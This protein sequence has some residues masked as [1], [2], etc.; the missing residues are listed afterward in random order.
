M[1]G[2]DDKKTV[3]DHVALILDGNRRWAEER[4][5]SGSEGHFAGYQTMRQ[6]P[7][8]F[9][10]R[11]VE[12]VSLFVF[13]TENWNRSP[14]EVN[15]LM[16]L[17]RQAVDEEKKTALEKGVR[18][19]VS[20]RLEELPGDLPDACR[21]LM[22]ATRGGKEGALNLCLNYGGR[23]E[24]E[25]A[26]KAIIKAGIQPDQVTE[27]LIRKYLY[28]GELPDPDIIVRTSGEMRTSG[29]LLWESHYAELFFLNKFW[30]DFEERDAKRI[31]EEYEKRNR[32][33]GGN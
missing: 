14:E 9:F 21:E 12:V 32:R 13:S 25:D 15:Y 20:G 10:S 30:P 29:F 18:I 33:F 31:L 24:I 23:A 26:I 27:E 2:S 11:G 19:L 17:L 16:K 4:N 6:A 3:P 22:D 28:H 8:W 7:G 5:L 1:L